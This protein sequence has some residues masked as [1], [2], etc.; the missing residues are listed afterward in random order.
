MTGGCTRTDRRALETCGPNATGSRQTKR[1]E[2]TQRPKH[3]GKHTD[4]SGLAKRVKRELCH[5]IEN[6]WGLSRSISEG[7]MPMLP[8]ALERRRQEA[9]E[10]YLA[11]DPIEVI[12]REMGCAKSWLY[13]WKKRY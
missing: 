5:D 12:C 7:K 1:G 6:K 3:A 4:A 2:V 11:G 13:K 9:L 8:S 10:R